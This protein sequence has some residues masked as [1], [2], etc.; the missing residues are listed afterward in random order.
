MNFESS[1]ELIS[2]I[3]LTKEKLVKNFFVT[4]FIFF[5]ASFLL[6][7]TD[8]NLD[9]EF[10]FFEVIMLVG[11]FAFDRFQTVT[12]GRN[13]SKT[14][15]EINFIDDNVVV[16]TADFKVLFWID[17]PSIEF[18][19]KKNQFMLRK[20]SYRVKAIYDIE[21]RAMKLSKGKIEVYIISDYFEKELEL[22]LR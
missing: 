5:G 22:R 8:K 3:E 18:N 21:N 16:K 19:F 7:E 13:I 9:L 4:L 2:L 14:A 10:V 17:N 12:I 6:Y 11:L 20:S 1:S 15:V